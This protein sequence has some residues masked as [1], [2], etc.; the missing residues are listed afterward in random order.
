MRYCIKWSQ[1]TKR[2]LAVDSQRYSWA[3]C[4][5]SAA[6][7]PAENSVFW[8]IT[9]PPYPHPPQCPM[10]QLAGLEH[11]FTTAQSK[12]SYLYGNMVTKVQKSYMSSSRSY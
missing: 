11:C 10:P 4:G 1:Y 5:Y 9:T 7:I 8:V 2:H 12:L 6:Q 3:L